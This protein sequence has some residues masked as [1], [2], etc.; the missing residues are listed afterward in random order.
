MQWNALL[1][2]QEGGLSQA[3]AGV[4][5]AVE[6]YQIL[7]HPVRLRLLQELCREDECVCHLSA[8]LDRPQPYVS[9]QLAELR[10][11][12][13]VADRRDGQRVYYHL[14]DCRVKPLLTAAGLRVEGVR[15]KVPG[16][17]CPKCE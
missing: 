4:D 1:P 7:A 17:P 6:L 5:S 2:C 9:Q 14:T 13:L 15:Q 16:C 12:G 11:A 10:N 8:L 3:A